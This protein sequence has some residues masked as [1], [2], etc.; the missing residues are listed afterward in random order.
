LQ[1]WDAENRLSVVTNTVSREV[2]KFVYDGDGN[3]MVQVY[4]STYTSTTA[5]FGNLL[6]ITAIGAPPVITTT[7]P[8]TLTKRFYLPLVIAQKVARSAP[9]GNE[10][11]K[12]YYAAGSQLVA[13]RAFT[14]SLTSTVYYLS[15][16]HLGSTS[17][18]FND[19]GVRIGEM[20]YRPYGEIR[21]ISGTVA[22]D[23]RFT[24]QYADAS[25]NLMFYNARFSSPLASVSR[26]TPARA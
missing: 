23:K 7:I 13:M 24:G 12:M 15:G 9:L 2:T 17:A 5:Y 26:P 19:S 8:P 25:T 10:T 20:R 18:I 16:D 21:Y 3:R 1:S 22:T 4:S 6:E 14:T 11:W